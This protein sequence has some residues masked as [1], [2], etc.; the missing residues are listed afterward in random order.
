M[1]LWVTVPIEGA[2]EAAQPDAAAPSTTSSAD[3]PGTSSAAADASAAAA[4]APLVS[5][6]EARAAAAAAAASTPTHP[7]PASAAADPWDHWHQFRALTDF[8]PLL[9]CVL[10][11]GAKLPAAPTVERWM[12]EPVKA[13]L[14][15]TAL[16]G[17]NKRGY[18]VLPKGHQD[19]IAKF[20]RNHVQVGEA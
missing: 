6:S 4:A 8:H 20:F 19:L 7:H 2:A 9:G 18:P 1:A 10:R 13:L 3:A 17:A 16:F 14:L 5:R 12:G 15:P 11:L